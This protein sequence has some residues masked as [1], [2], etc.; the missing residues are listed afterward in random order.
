[1][2]AQHCIR[3][4]ISHSSKWYICQKFFGTT[5]ETIGVV[6]MCIVLM[7]SGRSKPPSRP[8]GESVQTSRL[9]QQVTISSR[10]IFHYTRFRQHVQRLSSVLD[11]RKRLKSKSS[12]AW[13]NPSGVAPPKTMRSK[14][15]RY[16]RMPLLQHTDPMFPLSRECVQFA[17]P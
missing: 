17:T 11:F 9:W 13:K 16:T 10:V 8:R 3:C 4:H 15:Y 1:M 6:L 5:S 7:I 12:C 14:L 2:H